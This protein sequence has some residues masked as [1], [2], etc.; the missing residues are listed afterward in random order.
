MILR[1]TAAT[2]RLILFPGSRSS[3][4]RNRNTKHPPTSCRCKRQETAAIQGQQRHSDPRVRCFH[5][6]CLHKTLTA[7]TP[8]DPPFFCQ[9][10][11][12][13]IRLTTTNTTPLLLTLLIIL[14]VQYSD[15]YFTWPISLVTSCRLTHRTRN[16][17]ATGSGQGSGT[18]N[19]TDL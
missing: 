19:T 10:E 12:N 4:R 13:G 14:Y 8:T 5:L 1:R 17:I 9:Q 16:G 15:H 7:L 11:G 3:R 2:Y 18:H 6:V